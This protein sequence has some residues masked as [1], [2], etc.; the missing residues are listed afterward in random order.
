[1]KARYRLVTRGCR[2]GIYYCFD[3]ETSRRESLHTTNEDE[4]RQIVEAKNNAQ[5]QPVLNLQIAKAYLAGSDSGINTRTWQ[6]ALDALIQ[7]KH[8]ANQERWQRA[9]NDKAIDLIRN[10]PIIETKGESLFKVLHAGTVSTNVFL[11]QLH[12]FCVDMNWLP[13][14]LI[15]KRQWPPIRYKEKRGITLEEH[16]QIVEREKNPEFKAFYQLAWHLGASQSD[17]AHLQ[18]EDVD[19]STRVISFF[20][21]KT[22]WRGQQPPQIRFGKEVEEILATLPGTGPLFP[23]LIHKKEKHRAKE[24]KRRC[25]GLEIEGV[26]LHSYRYAWAERAKCAGYPE[27]YAQLALGHNS[28]AVHR[29]Y[30]KKA[31]VL[32]PPLEEYER[33]IIQLNAGA[34]TIEASTEEPEKPA[35]APNG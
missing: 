8:G 6:H 7:N 22:R 29:A 21:M 15:P 11:R 20:R 23:T 1:M 35:E 16:R 10:Q 34:K 19:W 30:A 9:V 12:N 27:R 5:R 4:A 14:P 18:A 28:K 2:G 26:S 24:F 33:K 32:L 25:V 3:K 13:W 31:T 17:L